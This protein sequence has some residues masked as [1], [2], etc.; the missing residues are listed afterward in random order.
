MNRHARD[1]GCVFV[2]IEYRLAPQH[3]FPAGFEDCIDG[4]RWC[5]EN[6]NSLGARKGPIIIMGKSAGG[7]LA[8]AVSLKLIDDGLGSSLLGIAP[9]QPITVHPNAVPVDLRSRYT[10]YEENAENTVN[11]SKVMHVLFGECKRVPHSVA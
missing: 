11:T 7:S 6:A 2:S 4:A 3:Q 1:I 10:A 5:I 8:F 9:C